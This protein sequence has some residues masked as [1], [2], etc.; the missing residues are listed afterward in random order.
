MGHPKAQKKSSKPRS[1]IDAFIALPDSEK[2]RIYQEIDAKSPRQLLEE[3]RPLNRKERLQWK[4]FQKK[5]GRPKIGKGAKI[6]SLTVERDL[7]K[8]ADALA[9]LE[10]ISRAQ[11]FARGLRSVLKAS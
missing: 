4:K 11:I 9:K 8:Q 10:G 3:S 7:L 1:S 2:D 6:I 5:M